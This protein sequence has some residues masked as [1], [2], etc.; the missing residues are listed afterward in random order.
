MI[1]AI[2]PQPKHMDVGCGFSSIN[3][4]CAE[5]IDT[6]LGVEAYKLVVTPERISIIAGSDRGII[7]G[8][9]TLAQLKLQD[10][11]KLPCLTIEDEPVFSWRSFHLDSARHFIS[12]EELKKMI[13]MASF[14]KLNRFHWHFADDQGW[15]IESKAF[16][17]L[18]EIGAYRRGDHFGIY[19][20]D[21]PEGAYYTRDEVKEIV[22]FCREHGIEVVPELDIPG[23]ATAMLAA[24]PELSCTGKAVE[25]ETRAGIFWD[26][27]CAG[28]E[29]VY[30]FVETLLDDLLELF[31][32]EYFHIGGDEVPK[33]QWTGCPHCKAL[34][35][36][37]GLETYQQ[38]QGYM[39]N[40]IAAY[41]RKRGRKAIVWNEAAYGGNL[42]PAVT[43]QLWTDDRDNHITSHVNNG[44]KLILSP[45]MHAYCDYPHSFISLKNLHSLD[46]EPAEFPKE[47]IMGTEC[48]AWAEYIRD[49]EWLESRCWPRYSAS[50]EVGWCGNSK[51]DYEDF[52]QRLRVIFPAFAQHGIHATPEAGWTPKPEDSVEELNT[53][54]QNTR[55]SREDFLK[56][57]GEV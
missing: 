41:L 5:S 34:M 13:A 18:H 50:A 56:A 21:V 42:D 26:I 10:S 35:E 16:P 43:V 53:F 30:A 37:E 33:T 3:T 54:K 51:P 8:R 55:A 25:V 11:E 20:S 36:V 45:M 15:R 23:H 24:Y 17:K 57:Q 38:L 29:E 48:L 52:C 9:Q 2:I 31:P 39:N 28:R 7:W 47:S 4:K 6:S 27:L 19:S 22:A 14:F 32:G 1:N 12:V 40:R 49:N 46:T 44:G